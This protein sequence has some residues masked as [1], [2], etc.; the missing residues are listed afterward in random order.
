[1]HFN[2]KNS[3]F[4]HKNSAFQCFK[5]LYIKPFRYLKDFKNNIKTDEKLKRADFLGITS[6]QFRIKS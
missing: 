6:L 1:V 2:H 3:A 5:A 4:H